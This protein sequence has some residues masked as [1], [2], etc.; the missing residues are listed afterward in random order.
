MEWP[1]NMASA[2]YHCLL[3]SSV[4][5]QPR[6]SLSYAVRTYP[7]NLPNP[8]VRDILRPYI[9]EKSKLTEGLICRSS[10]PN[11]PRIGPSY[12]HAK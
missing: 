1:R 5:Q 8:G 2:I 10:W 7:F 4:R 12:W 9:P 11:P 3:Y 6:K